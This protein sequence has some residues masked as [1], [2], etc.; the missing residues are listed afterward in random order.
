MYDYLV[1]E[2]WEHDNKFE[3]FRTDQER[4]IDIGLLHRGLDMYRLQHKTKST[5]S[6]ENE[7]D[8]LDKTTRS[9]DLI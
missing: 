2:Q 9:I 1:Q 8:D 5:T 3:D 4:I 7:R 6:I